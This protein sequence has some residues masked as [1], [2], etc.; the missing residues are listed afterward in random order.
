[1][2][3]IP[4]SVVSTEILKLLL[5]TVNSLFT[6]AYSYNRGEHSNPSDDD[7]FAN[8]LSIVEAKIRDTEFAIKDRPNESKQAITIQINNI[9]EVVG[10]INEEIKEIIRIM[11]EH[12]KIK[13]FASMRAFDIQD[14]QARLYGYKKKMSEYFDMLCK[15][16]MTDIYSGK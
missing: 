9:K 11:T 5:P 1:M 6:S 12:P 15:M 7:T 13:W 4:I 10:K 14:N 16:L 8:T 3:A 2:S